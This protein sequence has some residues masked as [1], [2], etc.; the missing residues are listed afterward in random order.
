M[1]TRQL[2]I[3]TLKSIWGEIFFNKQSTVTKITDESVLNANAFADSRLAQIILKEIAL[4]E[5]T[6]FP[7]Y[8]T[9]TNLDNAGMLFASLE[10]NSECQSSTTLLVIAASG[11]VYPAST[12]IFSSKSGIQFTLVDTLTIGDNGYG[13]APVTSIDTGLRAN[14]LAN[15]IT[16]VSPEPT[17]HTAVTNEFMAT[18]GSDDEIDEDFRARIKSH[19]NIVAQKTFAYIQEIAR[20]YNTD[21]LLLQ[22]LGFDNDNVFNIG[23]LTRNMTDLTTGEQSALLDDISPYLAMSDINKQ[24]DTLNIKLSN[25]VKFSVGGES[26]GLDFRVQLYDNYDSDI[27]RKNIQIGI[28]RF[29]DPR[30][31][32]SGG[33]ILWTDLLRIATE[34]SGVKYIPDKF[35][36]PQVD[37]IIPTNQFPRIKIFVMRDLDGNPISDNAGVLSDVFYPI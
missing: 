11:T 37:I 34:T 36:Y 30:K 31:W 2:T 35:F 25:A 13:Y 33:I 7:D 26:V 9:E 19:P 12:T 5:A 32:V 1:I 24:G 20:I 3:E 17:G 21:I 27:V 14:V 6:I 4:N 28:S 29:L 15:T 22:N 16:I 10:R 18:G 23:V 8:A